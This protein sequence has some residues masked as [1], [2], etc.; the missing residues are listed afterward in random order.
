MQGKNATLQAD[1]WTEGNHWHLV[2]FIIT[3]DKKVWTCVLYIVILDVNKPIKVYTVQVHDASTKRKTAD[4]FL[5][6]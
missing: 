4:R 6:L 3:V 5:T 2:A 1:G